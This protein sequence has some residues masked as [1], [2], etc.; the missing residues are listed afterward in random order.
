MS[1]TK[2]MTSSAAIN[3]DMRRIHVRTSPS[4]SPRA[5][6]PQRWGEDRRPLTWNDCFA[7][8]IVYLPAPEVITKDSSIHRQT[9]G[10]NKFG[11]PAVVTKVDKITGVEIM[12][13]SHLLLGYMPYPRHLVLHLVEE[14]SFSSS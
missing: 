9:W 7:G 10:G 2:T 4:T 3:G 1:A 11:H 5:S 13:V 6:T 14:D 12:I 8:L